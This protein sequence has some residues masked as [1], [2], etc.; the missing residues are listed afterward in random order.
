MT[1]PTTLRARQWQVAP[2]V[3]AQ[4]QQKF[5]HIPPI[6]LQIL[7]NRGIT[8]CRCDSEFFERRYLLEDD[9]FQ[10][11]DMDKAVMRIRQSHRR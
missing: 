8:R 1:R 6:L 5:S 2:P 9:P 7:Y 10:L 11:P 4:Y 3:P